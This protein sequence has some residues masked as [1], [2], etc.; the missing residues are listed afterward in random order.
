ML[1]LTALSSLFATTLALASCSDDSFPAPSA[2]PPSAPASTDAQYAVDGLRE[3]AIIG[4]DVD[5]GNDVLQLVVT[6]PSGTKYVDVWVGNGPGQRLTKSDGIFSIAVDITSLAAGEYELLL[7]ADG[8]ETAFI[9]H[10]FKRSHPLYVVVTTDW[11]DADTSDEALALQDALHAEHSELLLT[12]FVG[13]YTFTDPTVTEARRDTLVA[14]LL[15]MRSDFQDEIGLHIHP[16]CNFVD[17]VG[18]ILG[19]DDIE[20]NTEASTVYANGDSTGYTVQCSA[21]SEEDFT[22]MLLASDAVFEERGLGKPTS[23]RAG[24]WTTELNTM[25]SLE[26]AGYVAD[27][28][29]NNWARMEEWDG[30][31]MGTLYAWNREH[32]SSI[33]DTSQPYYPSNDDILV[34]GDNAIGVLEVPDNGILVDYVETFEMIEIFEANWDGGLLATPVNYS[35]GYHPSNFNA[36]YKLRIT[37]ALDHVDQFLASK[38][39]GPV[40]YGRLSDMA[41]VWKQE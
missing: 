38:D 33:G 11:D 37:K 35:I 10:S 6:A 22:N 41:K 19:I 16:Y 3:W 12:H 25:R 20:C 30:P 32:W 15:G 27:T 13:P 8:D 34:T 9:T 1:R 5:A 36:A 29:A 18:T 23:F 2:T 26:A 21:Y 40:I 7:A 24:G 14:W 31:R 17:E 39:A 28:S 4:N